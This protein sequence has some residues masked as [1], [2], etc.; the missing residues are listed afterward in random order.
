MRFNFIADFRGNLS[1][2][3]VCAFMNFSSRGYRAYLSCRLSQSQC[4][5]LVVLAHIREQFAISLRSYGSP[6]LSEELKEA[7]VGIR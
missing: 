7:G 6:R 5:D 2:N 4:K 1:I 3:R